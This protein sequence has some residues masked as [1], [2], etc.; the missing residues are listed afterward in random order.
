MKFLAAVGVATLMGIVIM[1]VQE[2]RYFILEWKTNRNAKK[3]QCDLSK[4]GTDTKIILEQYME[5]MYRSGKKL[6]VVSDVKK[7]D[8]FI[9]AHMLYDGGDYRARNLDK[10]IKDSLA[11][12][13]G[14]IIFING[15]EY[16]AFPPVKHIESDCFIK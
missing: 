2:L 16:V 3:V 15:K 4:V 6:Y 1:S 14:F 7:F 11:D 9:S 8:A 12:G 10:Y 5:P 13:N